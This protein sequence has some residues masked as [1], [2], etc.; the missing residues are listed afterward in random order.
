MDARDRYLPLLG[1]NSKQLWIYDEVEGV[2]IDPP[3]DVLDYI[4]EHA[5]DIEAAE[6]LLS[7]MAADEAA[8]PDGGWLMDR[9]YWW[10][11]DI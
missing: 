6:R 4:D 10:T 5:A 9:E 7:E 11:G 1:P 3:A 8:K 2:Y